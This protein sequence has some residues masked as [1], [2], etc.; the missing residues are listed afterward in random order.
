MKKINLLFCTLL[1]LIALVSCEEENLDP[2]GE[3]ELS[4]PAI[5][6]GETNLVLDEETPSEVFSF[7]WDPAVSSERY[8]VRYAVVLD[9]VGSTDYSTPVLR[10]TSGNGGKD[11]SISFTA[12]EIDLAL[13]YAGFQVAVASELEMAVI[14]TSIDKQTNDIQ[15][16]SITRFVN[17]SLP[18]QLYLS[19]AATE[20]GTDL[21]QGIPMRTL[22][23]GDGN[24]TFNFEVYTH[25][26][27][28]GGFKLYSKTELPA[29]VYGGENGKII[30]NGPAITAPEAGEYRISVN[31]NEKTYQLLK[32]D[33]FSFVGEG[34]PNGWGGDEPLDYA[35]NGV[36]QKELFL[37]V[38]ESGQG[39]FLF[40]ANGDWAYLFKRIQGTTNEVYMESQAEA[41]GVAIEDITFNESGNYLV[42]LDLSKVPY[43]YSLVVSENETS[44]PPSSTPEALY[45][46]ADGVSVATFT[47]DGN[48]FTSGAYLPLREPVSYQ[49]NSAAD[50]SGTAYKLSG[51]IG[52]SSNPDGDAV[53][54]NLD[55]TERAGDITVARDQAYKLDFDFATGKATWKYYNIKLFHWDEPGG[56]WDARNEFLMTYVHPHKF[57]TTQELKA[58]YHM[59]FNSPWEVQFGAD[60]AAAMSGTM[61][62]NGGANFTNITAS[63]TYTVNIET[64]G[65]YATGTYEFVKQ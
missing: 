10:K 37:Q 38:P 5:L 18:E 63:G 58:G 11:T 3:W 56:G 51:S 28:E 54:A 15:T 64:T 2:I 14:A 32:I 60:D 8:Q 27:S 4:A 19:G 49:L 9:T 25:L 52:E 62:N 40:R 1:A 23:D 21:S 7:S 24:T 29:N 6:S 53:F 20:A 41:G 65:D 33:R 36:W 35:G 26:D 17:G 43:T 16:V 30:I 61:T 42:T 47:K 55:L 22:K 34:I 59:K 48:K 44:E 12:S 13:S 39:G 46:L 57:T 45:L 50:G 31:L